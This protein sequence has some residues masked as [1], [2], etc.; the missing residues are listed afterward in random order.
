MRGYTLD[1]MRAMPAA[2]CRSWMLNGNLETRAEC[3]RCFWS[4]ESRD[5][6]SSAF[7]VEIYFF[8]C[9]S[10]GEVRQS[11]QSSRIIQRGGCKGDLSQSFILCFFDLFFCRDYGEAEI[12]EDLF[13]EAKEKGMVEDPAVFLKLVLMYVD[14]GMAEKII[15]IIEAVKDMRIK[16]SDCILCAVVNVYVSKRGSQGFTEST[17]AIEIAETVSSGK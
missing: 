14:M 11:F 13:R 1:R 10:L 9:D 6:D 5:L 7:S 8:L 17:R 4:F 12:A 3:H 16:I 15:N 2:I